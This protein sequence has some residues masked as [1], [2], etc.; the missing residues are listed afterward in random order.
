MIPYMAEHYGL[1]MFFAGNNYEWPRG[2]IDAAKRCLHKLD[3]D[4]VGEEYLPIG[5]SGDEINA[6]LELVARS[7]ADVFVPYFA[8]T[9]QLKLLTGFAEMGLKK[10]M[11]VVMGHFDE[12]LASLLPA[13]VREGFYSSNTYFMSLDREENRA[14]FQKLAA[15]P[16]IDGIWP[17]GNGILTNFGEATYVCVKAFAKAVEQAGS[18]ANEALVDA[19]ETVSVTAPQGRVSM[20]AETHHAWVNT[21]L[22]RCNADGSFR[23]VERFELNPPRIPERYSRQAAELHISP[24]SPQDTGQ[25]MQGAKSVLAQ[26]NAAQQILSIA[27]MAI[28]A[29]DE[30][31]IITEATSTP[32]KCSAIRARKFWVC[33]C[34]YCCRR[35]FAS[36]TPNWSSGLSKATRRN[37][38]WVGAEN[39]PVTARTARFFRWKL[40]SVKS[41]SASN[42]CWS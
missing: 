25:V 40:R 16:G 19:L 14:Y 5:A 9:D 7:G 18:T 13:H 36:A 28:L 24:P 17:N 42:G 32:A 38:I 11:A 8:G 12:V 15:E 10:H 29:A 34:T 20:D 4:V 27:D 22:A 30:N 21:Y 6:L 3:G 2:S 35:I 37:A 41:A 26:S 39:W 23:I 1:K 31:G 33:R